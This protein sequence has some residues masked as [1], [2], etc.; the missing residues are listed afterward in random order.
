LSLRTYEL[1][2][3]LDPDLEPEAQEAI[4]KRSEE[5]ISQS[6][7]KLEKTDVWGRRYLSYEIKHKK[8]AYYLLYTF[9]SNPEQV[10]E[11]ERVLGI[12]DGVLR[13]RLFVLP[14]EALKGKSA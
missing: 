2:I 13:F 12:I 6:G 10:A 14:P 4:T 1:M 9:T 3:L 5:L 8:E 7:G 11:I